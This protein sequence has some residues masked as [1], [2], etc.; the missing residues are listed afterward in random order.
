MK[1]LNVAMIVTTA[2]SLIMM[3][4]KDVFTGLSFIMMGMKDVFLV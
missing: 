3:G 2:L 4:M 1:N